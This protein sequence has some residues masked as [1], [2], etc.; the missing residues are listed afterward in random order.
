MRREE[1]VVKIN[2][3]QF[4]PS[5]MIAITQVNSSILSPRKIVEAFI[6]PPLSFKMINKHMYNDLKG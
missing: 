3:P 6:F 2:W 5:I 1:T 4:D